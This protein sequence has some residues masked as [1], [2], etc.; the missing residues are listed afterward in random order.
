M[1]RPVNQV[2]RNRY[3]RVNIGGSYLNNITNPLN[4]PNLEHPCD[5]KNGGCSMICKKN[6]PKAKCE[7]ETGF[8]LR[9]D[10]IT[11]EKGK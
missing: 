3:Q 4:P 5:V 10:K 11:C 9:A 2:S 7:C 8:K 1:G 6:G